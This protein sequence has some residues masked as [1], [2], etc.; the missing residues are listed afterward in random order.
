MDSELS[1]I[2]IISN[3]P[4]WSKRLAQKAIEIKKNKADLLDAAEEYNTRFK[5]EVEAGTRQRQL[6]LTEG[7][8]Q[9]KTEDQ[10][11]MEYGK[12]LPT[13]YTPI[14][15]LLYFLLREDRGQ[16]SDWKAMRKDFYAATNKVDEDA[17]L[18]LDDLN[19]KYGH[20]IDEAI[21][22]NF[23]DPKPMDEY[24]YGNCTH[25]IFKR[26]KKL[27]ALSTSKNRNE[28]FVAYT[29]C[30]KLCEKYKLEFDKIPCN[31]E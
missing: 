13:K 14:L 27:K 6:L 4:D 22:Q 28:A 3:D 19:H 11:M 12:F 8:I 29:A 30:M 23:E 16:A 17:E 18:S 9:G 15:N 25:D 7:E 2:A 24:I 20:L 5:E 21:L 10:V 26:I 1:L 31:V